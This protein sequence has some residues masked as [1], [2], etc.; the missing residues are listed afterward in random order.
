M[1]ALANALH[2]GTMRARFHAEPDCQATEL[3]LQERTPRDVD[4]IRPREEEVKAAAY[5]RELIPPS[6]R[7]FESPH[8]AAVQ[9]QLLSN[10]RYAVMMTAAGSGYSR[11]GDLAVTRW[12]EDPTRD[13]WGSYVFLRDVDSGA[14][15]SAG[16]QPT[17]VEPDSYEASFFEDRVEISRR[18]GSIT[19]RLEVAVSPEDDVEVRRVTIS[20][21]GNRAREIELTSYAEIVLAPQASDTAHPAFSNLF[22]QTE[23][24]QDIGAVLATRRRGSPEEPEV[25]AA[26]FTVVEGDAFGGLQF[27]TDRAR[28]LGRGRFIRTP[29][30]GH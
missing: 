8:Q 14:V 19:T 23:F 10:G 28:F 25:W 4:A 29:I 24:V 11:W 12:H 6:L 26:H 5:V 22:V 1:V 17:A 16:Y 13:C 18:D 30:C 2:D 9:T 21:L 15:W 27:E 3:L 7:R 20:N